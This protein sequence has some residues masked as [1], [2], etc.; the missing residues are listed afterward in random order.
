MTKEY[1]L[2]ELLKEEC[3]EIIQRACKA[4][5]FSLEESQAGQSLTNEE[6]I[7]YEINDLYAVLELLHENH[8]VNTN[9]NRDMIENK[10]KKIIRY[11]NYS[12]ELGILKG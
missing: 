9:A 7:T 8:V 10:K 1:Y 4:A 3:A 5:R 12:N 6:R 11:M 2:L